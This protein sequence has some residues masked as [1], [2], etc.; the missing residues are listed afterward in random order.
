MQNV[1]CMY[2]VNLYYVNKSSPLKRSHLSTRLFKTNS[3]QESIIPLPKKVCKITFFLVTRVKF[4][5]ACPS[6]HGLGPGMVQD[7]KMTSRPPAKTHSIGGVRQP[8]LLWSIPARTA[9]SLTGGTALRLDFHSYPWPHWEVTGDYSD[10]ASFLSTT[11]ESMRPYL[12]PEKPF[13][14]HHSVIWNCRRQSPQNSHC[15]ICQSEGHGKAQTY[16]IAGMV[17]YIGGG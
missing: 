12:E 16:C 14:F 5:Y 15:T 7:S 17:Q 13:R 1:S 6:D 10:P 2:Y 11:K 8:S 3:Q 4:I 9:T